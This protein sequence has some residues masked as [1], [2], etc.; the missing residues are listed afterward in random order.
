VAVLGITIEDFYNMTPKEFSQA[1]KF[2][3]ERESQELDYNMKLQ[4]VVARFQAVL[5][6][7]PQLPKGKWIRDPC[8]LVRFHWE[9][10]KVQSVDEMKRFLQG[11]AKSANKKYKKNASN[12]K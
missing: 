4:Y 9:A 2:K 7:N 6:I 8:E 5:L 3:Y 11:M 12:T 10:E 1:L